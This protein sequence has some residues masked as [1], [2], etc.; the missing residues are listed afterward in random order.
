MGE[1]DDKNIVLNLYSM[2]Q[3]YTPYPMIVFEIFIQKRKE[4]IVVEQ[5]LS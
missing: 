1:N 4:T 3:V 5:T 2:N